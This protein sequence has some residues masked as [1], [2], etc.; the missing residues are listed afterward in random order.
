MERLRRRF[1]GDFVDRG[2]FGC[3]V[4]FTLLAYKLLDPESIY[5]NRGKFNTCVVFNI[6]R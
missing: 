3:E 6:F 1:N 5:M 2:D 4:V